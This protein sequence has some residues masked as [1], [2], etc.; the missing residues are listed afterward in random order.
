MELLDIGRG[1][2]IEHRATLSGVQIREQRARLS[3][4]LTGPEWFAPPCWVT[5]RCFDLE[6][7]GTQIAEQACGVRCGESV[8]Q[9]DDAY[10]VDQHGRIE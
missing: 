4:L 5:R 7:I 3:P 1:V 8:A 2:E 10:V 9:F 6:D